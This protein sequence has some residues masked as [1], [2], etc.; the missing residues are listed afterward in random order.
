[1]KILVTG[2]AGFI[3]SHLTDN[4][5]ERDHEVVIVDNL[6]RGKKEQVNP[7][8]RFYQIDIRDEKLE[9][10]F[11]TEKPDVVDHHAAQID[12]RKSVEDP[13]NDAQNN[14]LGSLNVIRFSQKYEVKKVVFAST[15]GAIYGD[16]AVIPTPEDYPAWPTSPYGIAK[17]TVEHYLYFYNHQYGLKYVALRYG[18]VYG[19]RQDPHGEAGVVAIFT[20][21]LLLREQPIINGSGE[22]T[23]DYVFVKDVVNANA[24]AIESDATGSFNVGTGVKTSV[25]EIFKL[26]NKLTDANQKEVHTEEKPGEQKVSCLDFTKINKSMGWKPTLSFEEGLAETVEYFRTQT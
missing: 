12:V 6:Y 8:A 17:L 9:E 2:G 24:M 10:I 22:Q 21:K 13:I 20:K 5:I 23:R 16:A 26:L 3:A 7:K 14:I 19:P 11:K 1:M 4:L 25:N 18:N 15:G